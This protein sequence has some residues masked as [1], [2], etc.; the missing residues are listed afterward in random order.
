[1]V[2][3]VNRLKGKEWLLKKIILKEEDLSEQ[4]IIVIILD[5]DGNQD[6]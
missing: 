4:D 6:F 3:E 5:Q 1:L 2:L